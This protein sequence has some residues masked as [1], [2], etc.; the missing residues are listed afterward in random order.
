[1]KN[2]I[3]LCSGGIDSITTAYYVR[4]RL[5]YD[6]LIILFFNYKQ[7]SL[8]SERLCAK[9]CAIDLN[10]KFLEINL[11]W[12]G[13]ISHSIIN[14]NKSHKKIKRKELKDTRKESQKYYVPSRNSIFIINAISISESLKIKEKSDYDIFVGFK[15][16]GNE[17]YPDTTPEFVN[18]MNK[19]I[20]N[21]TKIKSR[22][23]APMI[24]KDKEDII[25]IGMNLGLNFDNTFTCYVGKEKHCGT[26]L[27]CRLRQ[28]GFYWANVKDSTVYK[29]RMKDSR[30]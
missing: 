6:K 30:S 2:A 9:K 20:K 10:G 29:E 3:V 19:L 4:K 18:Q 8:N 26:C 11:S 7:R 23:I 5:K 22:I 21:T 17:F 27:A 28:E 1:M 12:L 16:E 25:K 24:K 14:V 15:A 13:N